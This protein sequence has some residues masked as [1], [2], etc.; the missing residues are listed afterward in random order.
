MQNVSFRTVD[1]FLDFLIEEDLA[2]VQRLR[3]IIFDAIPDVSE[4]LSYNVPYYR[5]HADICFIWP[6]S[7]SWGDKIQSGVRFGFTQGYLLP[8]DIGFLDKGKRKQVYWHDFF[9]LQD[10]DEETLASYLSLAVDID[11]QRFIDK[12]LNR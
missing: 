4:R 12:K 10:I 8:D 2:I 3:E 11:E 9:S 5:R 7:I 6:G 1:E